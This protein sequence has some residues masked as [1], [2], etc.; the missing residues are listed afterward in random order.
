MSSPWVH[1]KTIFLDSESGIK[2]FNKR[3]LDQLLIE[4]DRNL[5]KETTLVLI[6]GTALVVKYRSPRATMD[7]DTYTKISKDFLAAW[8]KAEK[9]I[10][11]SVP[12]S[13]SVISEGPYAMEDRFTFYRDLDLT[14]L[15]ILVPDPADLVLMKVLRFFGKDRD[16]IK[17]LISQSRIPAATLLKRYRNEMNH[18]VGDHQVIKNHYLLAIEENFGEKIADKHERSIAKKDLK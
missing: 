11:V 18:I 2:L 17:H 8:H 10:G 9:K 7:V 14:H 1:W 3:I 5:T 15:K 12:I 6:G 4:T 13:R 16:D